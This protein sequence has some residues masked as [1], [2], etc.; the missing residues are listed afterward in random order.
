MSDTESHK[1]QSDSSLRPPRRTTAETAASRTEKNNT[2]TRPIDRDPPPTLYVDL[3]G[4][5]VCTD[6]LIESVVASVKSDPKTLLLI[7]GWMIKGRPALKRG[8]AAR[9]MPPVESLPYRPEVIE[10]LRRRRETGRLVLATAADRSVAE[11]IAE[12][13]GLF[14]DVL[15]TEPGVNL[16]G[17]AKLRAIREHAGDE[18]FAYLG[19]STADLP[20]WAEASERLLAG[21]TPSLQRRVEADGKPARP[22]VHRPAI[23]PALFAAMRPRQWIKNGL[24]L[25]PILAGHAVTLGNFASV[26]V[27][28]VCF[29]LAAS[30]VYLINDVLDVNADRSHPSKS[31]RA[32]ASGRLSLLHAIAAS[33]V[34][35]GLAILLALVCLPLAFVGWLLAYL[36]ITFLYCVYLRSRLLLDVITLAGLYTLRVFAGGAVVDIQP[37]FWLL[38]LAVFLFLSLGF[39]KRFAELHNSVDQATVDVKH[40]SARNYTPADR[41]LL[42]T[43]GVV[44]GYAAA[45][46]LCLYLNDPTSRELYTRPAILWLVVPLL[47]YWVSRAWLFAQRGKMNED[48]VAW[49]VGDRVSWLFVVTTFVL[50]WLA[51]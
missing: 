33:P 29:S 12:H 11:R 9:A 32:I 16:K 35:I 17:A 50:A 41:G 28:I 31:R 21:G 34:F 18:P 3:D 5:L 51:T 43:M 19:D 25:A 23:G 14:D 24:L 8:L 22:L 20:I 47:L 36:A 45:V 10:Y 46:V 1:P 37:S 38:T 48:P 42:Q 27:G 30:S 15:A 4:A 26:L 2:P 13:L 44:S 6:I 40:P 7:P 39:L 49:A